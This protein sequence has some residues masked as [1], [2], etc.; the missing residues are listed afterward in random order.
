MNNS[1]VLVSIITPVYNSERFIKETIQS[2]QKQTYANWEIILVDDCSTDSSERIIRYMIEKDPKI[3]YIKLENNS[4]AAVARNT[5]IKNS[6]GRFIAFLDSDD[7]WECD[8]LEKQIKFMLN[9]DIGFS[10]TGYNLIDEDGNDLDKVIKVPDQIDYDGLLKNTIIGCLTVMIDRSKI[11]DFR[12]PLIRAGQDTAT[13]LSILKKGYIA[14]GLNEP[15]ARY[16]K[17]EGSI[18][19]NKIKA[20]K[21]TWNIYR[22]LEK[23]PL[24]KTVYV[25]TCYIINALK[26]R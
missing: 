1:S 22:N 17:V 10:F 2:V 4:G 7:L 18:S 21:R 26:K 14:Y 16:R 5:A 25:F 8:K 12:M 15:L 3:K 6:K 9:K 20:L 23:L 11:G 24:P 13:W 19:S